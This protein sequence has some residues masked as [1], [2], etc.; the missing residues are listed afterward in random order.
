MGIARPMKAD[1][2][3]RAVLAGIN[4]LRFW[5]KTTSADQ[6]G[7]DVF[8]HTR[9]VGYVARLLADQRAQTLDRF[10]LSATEASVMA[11]FHDIGKISQGFQACSPRARG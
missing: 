7:I 9:N 11:A 4:N 5:A 3:A 10:R 6:P 2:T 1:Q 8:H